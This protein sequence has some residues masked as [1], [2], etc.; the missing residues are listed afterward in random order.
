MAW[1]GGAPQQVAAGPAPGVVYGGF[2]IRLVAYIIDWV[3]WIVV[4][5]VLTPLGLAAIGSI[6]SIVYFIGMWGYMGQTVGMMPFGLRV[7]R[8]D[9]G[10]K[11]T[12]TQAILR[13]I[14]MIISFLC[15][16]IGVIWVAFDPKKQGWH[17]KIGGTV[18]IKPA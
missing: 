8:A 16:F 7:V 3:L 15:I 13:Y 17:D 10:A 9:N 11:I 4:A 12:W 1:Q 2:W 5:A 18:V 14:G 6:L